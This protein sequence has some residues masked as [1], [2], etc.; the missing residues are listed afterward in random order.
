MVGLA[1]VCF[2]V[3]AVSQ[4]TLHTARIKDSA[5]LDWA[6]QLKNW[7]ILLCSHV[8]SD[9]LQRLSLVLHLATLCLCKKSTAW[10][11][12]WPSLKPLF[13]T[14][15]IL[16]LLPLYL[17]SRLYIFVLLLDASQC[18]ERAGRSEIMLIG[19]GLLW[20]VAIW[21]CNVLNHN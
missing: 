21:S 19:A 17:A 2:R 9:R 13:V 4:N 12:E 14:H 8:E 18:K 1:I 5:N 11:Q 15:L 3:P 7:C 16:L 10:R 20:T 6:G